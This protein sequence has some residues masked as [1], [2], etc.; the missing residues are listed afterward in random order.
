MIYI[1]NNLQKINNLTSIFENI[2]GSFYIYQKLKEN[3]IECEIFYHSYIFKTFL[4]TIF[5]GSGRSP[6]TARSCVSYAVNHKN[7]TT[8]IIIEK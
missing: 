1:N 2:F 5:G 3:N 4:K 6:N 8:T 7:I